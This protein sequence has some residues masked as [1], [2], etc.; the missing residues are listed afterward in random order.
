MDSPPGEAD[1][2]ALLCDHYELTALDAALASGIAS[3]SATFEV[4]ARRLPPGRR[5]GVL[6][7]IGR[8]VGLLADFRYRESELDHLA[9]HHVVSERLLDHLA[10][11]RFTG[12]IEAYREGDL[13]FPYSP[14]L[15]VTAPFG[16]A[17]VLETALL[18]ILNHDSAVASA[19]ARMHDVADGRTLIEGGSRR[20]HESAAVA[21]ARA[22][23][24]AGFDV[25]SNLEA[26]RRWGVPT[27]GTTMH[28]FVLAHGSEREAF[29][30]QIDRF[31]CDTT[32]LVDTYDAIEGVRCAIDACGDRDSVP[33]AIRIDSGD[34]GPAAQQARKMLD[35]DGC[36]STRIIV[37]G[38]LDEFA[39]RDLSAVRD[40]ADQRRAIDGFLVG[41]Q[42]ATGSG[43]PTAGFVYK[44]VAVEDGRGTV[45][46]VA[47]TST[48]KETI[49]GRKRA[50]RILDASGYAIEER[51]VSAAGDVDE[52]PVAGSQRDL[53]HPMIVNGD[54][55]TDPGL[56]AVRAFHLKARRELP[57]AAREIDPGEPALS[58][59][60]DTA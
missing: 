44:L 56:S 36:S 15:T 7:G 25:S 6:A 41:T 48:G 53:L 45:R 28:A 46:P 31:G 51:V 10:A 57:H 17:L 9:A 1:S 13:Y 38:D 26:G 27:G 40:L 21:A 50:A 4:F 60:S 20:V 37:S 5:Y 59:S 42:V 52:R 55:V 39:I 34:L 22:S 24:L 43:E 33:G 32:F 8:I 3:R 2:T 12:S 30:A 49:G 23:Y 16:D 18:S 35:A 14:V 29:D 19:A 11:W 47:K 58:G 54:V